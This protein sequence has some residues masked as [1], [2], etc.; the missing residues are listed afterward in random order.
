[1]VV[2]H[3]QASTLPSAPMGDVAVGIPIDPAFSMA[4]DAALP[5]AAHA[6]GV[7]ASQLAC[8]SAVEALQQDPWQAVRVTAVRPSAPASTVSGHGNTRSWRQP[9]AVAAPSSPALAKVT[10]P[11]VDAEPKHSECMPSNSFLDSKPSDVAATSCEAKGDVWRNDQ[12]HMNVSLHSAD[13]N[14]SFEI[15]AGQLAEVAA[16]QVRFA[17]CVMI[18]VTCV[19][20]RSRNAFSGLWIRPGRL[21]SMGLACCHAD[22]KRHV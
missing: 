14:L 4:T 5:R 21:S 3:M 11:C 9:V 15:N 18:L 19:L 16:I 7:P 10:S 13:E 8:R 17:C 1:M 2:R 20:S 22:K 12:D 6:A